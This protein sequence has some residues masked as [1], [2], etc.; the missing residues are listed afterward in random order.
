MRSDSDRQKFRQELLKKSKNGNVVLWKNLCKVGKTSYKSDIRNCIYKKGFI[1]KS[2][3]KTVYLTDTEVASS[4]I[5]YGIHVYTK[6][7]DYLHHLY[8]VVCNLADLVDINEKEAV[9]MKVK[10]I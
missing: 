6:K 7:Q 9:F 2:D 5:Y 1:K 3:R 10:L 8:R 4:N